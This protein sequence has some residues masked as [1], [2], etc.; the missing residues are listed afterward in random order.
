[1]KST[2]RNFLKIIIKHFPIALT[3]N[4]KYDRQTAKVIRKVLKSNSNSIDIGCHKGEIMDIFL[5]NA[6]QGIHY[7]FEPLPALYK[8]LIEKYKSTKNCTILPYALSNNGGNAHFNHVIED[9]ALSGLKKRE[10]NPSFHAEDIQVETIK[11]D[12]IYPP[13]IKLDFVKIDVEGGELLVL[14]GASGT[15]SKNKPVIIFEHGLGASE[16]YGATPEKLFELLD[17]FGLNVSTMKKWLCD[18]S[19]FSLEE[20]KLQYYNKLNY[21]FIAYPK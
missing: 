21:Y 11:L 5:E 2:I 17:S 3:R 10:Y 14:E 4:I 13:H 6:P 20:F 9:P 7:G 16:F 8:V 19:P 1:M 15:L 18:K 12:D